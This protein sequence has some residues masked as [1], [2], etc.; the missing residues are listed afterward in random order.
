MA[1]L[2]PDAVKFIIE[3][4]NSQNITFEKLAK[5]VTKKIRYRNH[6]DRRATSIYSASI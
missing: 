6:S 3:T 5:M 2:Y 4:R 1:K